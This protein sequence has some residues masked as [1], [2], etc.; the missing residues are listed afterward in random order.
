MEAAGS[1]NRGDIQ[2]NLMKIAN[3]PGTT[4]G[5]GEIAKGLKVLASGGDI[6]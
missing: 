2:S 4:I 5:P 1:A 3:A 6:D